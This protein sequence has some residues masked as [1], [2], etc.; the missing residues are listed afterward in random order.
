M[1]AIGSCAAP[2]A[3]KPIATS[4]KKRPSCNVRFD[5]IAKVGQALDQ[6]LDR[7]VCVTS[8][9]IFQKHSSD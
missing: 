2:S 6:A 3:S 1:R 8:P 7:M 5:A 9:M 4:A